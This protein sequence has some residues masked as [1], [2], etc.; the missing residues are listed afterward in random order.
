MQSQRLTLLQGLLQA[1]PNDTF[2]LFALAKE[3]EKL[4]QKSLALETYLQLIQ[5]DAD[6]IG[7]YYHLGK[8]YEALHEPEKALTTYR[9]GMV[10]AN[11]LG[12]THAYSELAGAKLNLSDDE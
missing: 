2:V 8:L 7:L 9:K 12:D 6:Y 4:D 10:I 5:V 1:Q 3:Y 11:K